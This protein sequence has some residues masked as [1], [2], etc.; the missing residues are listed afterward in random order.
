MLEQVLHSEWVTLRL[1]STRWLNSDGRQSFLGWARALRPSMRSGVATESASTR[2][3]FCAH[4]KGH[5]KGK[6]GGVSSSSNE[7]K[8]LDVFEKALKK[9][10]KQESK[11]PP[12]NHANHTNA[13]TTTSERDND[14]R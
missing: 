8:M 12:T 7:P 4:R 14:A 6:V 13:T 1:R 9:K 10:V 2:G 3:P 11:T 5:G